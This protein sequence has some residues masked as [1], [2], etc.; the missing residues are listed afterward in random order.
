MKITIGIP[1]YNGTFRI[2][3]LLFSIFS[4][5]DY[6]DLKDVRIAV[7]DDG[8]PSEEQ[9]KVLNSLCERSNVKFIKHKQNEGIA[10]SWNS[11]THAFE[12]VDLVILFNDDIQ[13]CH[14]DWLRCIK[15][16]FEKNEKIGHL[17][18]GIFHRDPKTGLPK[19]G[20]PW[21]DVNRPPEF[22]W[23]PGG[24]AFAFLKSVYDETENGFCE[25]L[26]SFYEESFFGYELAFK[27]CS[28]YLL[29]FP[30]VEHWGSQTFALNKELA[31]TMPLPELPM[32]KY[33]ELLQPKFSNEKIEPLP[34]FVYRMEYSRCLFALKWGCM[35]LWDKPQDEIEI[36]LQDKIKKRWIRWLDKDENEREGLI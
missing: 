9:V 3:R 7:V 25:K 1:T 26:A 13:I 33:R 5:T 30:I 6:A 12:D 16:F 14:S 36:R 29:S 17:S 23:T 8:T 32:E 22:S 2:K 21:P 11:L 28:S 24:Q 35:D 15:Y 34:G 20:Y 27:G 18:L 31:Y 19:E 4:F 10:S